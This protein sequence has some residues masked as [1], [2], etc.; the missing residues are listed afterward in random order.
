MMSLIDEIDK[1]RKS[2]PD[3]RSARLDKHTATYLKK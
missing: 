1:S 2:V 3:V